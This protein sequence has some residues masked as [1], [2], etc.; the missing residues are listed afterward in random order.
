M[1][2]AMIALEVVAAASE[3]TLAVGYRANEAV[4]GFMHYELF[5]KL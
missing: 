1:W 2:M 3:V 5:F 4:M